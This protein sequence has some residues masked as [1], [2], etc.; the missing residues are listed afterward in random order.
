MA[1]KINSG[2]STTGEP[3]VPYYVESPVREAAKHLRLTATRFLAERASSCDLDAAIKLWHDSTRKAEPK[4]CDPD[5]A[6]AAVEV[7]EAAWLREE[8]FKLEHR[9]D[10]PPVTE[11]DNEDHVWVTV[12]VHVPALDI[13]MWTDGA[14]SGGAPVDEL[15]AKHLTAEAEVAGKE[16]KAGAKVKRGTVAPRR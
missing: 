3:A 5:R 7:L 2:R 12:R 6:L 16:R 14:H 13:D 9:V 10:D 4:R 11:M 1:R 8:K 15:D